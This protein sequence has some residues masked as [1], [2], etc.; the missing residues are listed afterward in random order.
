MA[1]ESVVAD[2]AVILTAKIDA[3]VA[4]FTEVGAS[5]EEMATKVTEATTQVTAASDKMT[6]SLAKVG[7]AADAAATTTNTQLS[8]ASGRFVSAGAAA[9]GMGEET[10]VAS[11]E[12]DAAT[13]RMA[14]ALEK[15]GIASETAATENKLAMEAMAAQT[16]ALSA[17][18]ELAAGKAAASNEGITAA[19]SKTG[20]ESKTRTRQMAK[21]FGMAA[22]AIGGVGAVAV[23]MAAKFQTSTTKLMTSAGESEQSI[24]Q[25]RQGML[26]MAGQV[27]VSAENLS[28]AMYQIESAGYHAQSGLGVLKAAEEGAKAEGADG[29][30]VAEALT[31]A[32][33]DYYPHAQSAADVTK[34]STDV[35]SKFIGATS[36]GKM[37]FDDL[38]GALSN[39][40]PAA[41]AANISLSDT[42]GVLASMT[43]HGIS[44]DQ[45]TQN[46]SDA[47]RHLQTPTQAMSKAMATLGIDSQD[48]AQ[49]LGQR[50]LSGTMQYLSD[51][52]KKAMPPGSDKVLLDLGNAASKSSPAVQDLAK[53]VLDGSITMGEFSKAAKGLDPISAKQAQAFAT[54]AGSYHQL[55]NQQ[56]SGATVMQTYS[57]M[58]SKVMGDATGLK[59]ALMTTK[60]NAGYTSDA[61]KQVANS[62]AEAGGN[63]K[64][65]HDVQDTFNQKLAESKAALGSMAIQIGN[66]LIP[67]LTPVV[68]LVGDIAMWLGKHPAVAQAAAIAIAALTVGFGA[69]AVAMWAASSTPVMWI[70]AAIVAVVVLLIAGIVLLV[71]HWNEVW[72]AV[73]QALHAVYTAVIKPVIDAIVTAAKAVGAAFTWLWQNVLKPVFD[74]ISFAVRAVALVIADVF[75][76]PTI[77]LVRI[78]AAIFTWLW[79]HAVK[80]AI[81]AI[82]RNLQGLYDNVF[83]PVGEAIGVAIHAIGDAAKWVWDNAIKPAIDAITTA[84]NWLYRNVFTPVGH[85]IQLEI[86]AIGTAASWV[87]DNVLKPVIDALAGAWHWVYDNAIKPVA[88]FIGSAVHGVGQAFSDAFNWV[89]S[90]VQDVWNFIKPIFDAIGNAIGGVSNA[91]GGIGNMISGTFSGIAHFLGFDDGGFVPGAP[92]QPMLAVVHGGEYVVSN[93]MQNGS[94]P[95][96]PKLGAQLTSSGGAP[97]LSAGLTGGGSGN[98]VVQIVVQGNAVTERQLID[99][100]QQGMLRAGQHRPVTYQNYRR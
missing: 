54:L 50:G 83:K 60:D 48:I 43:V 68:K 100:V 22:V 65:W 94:Q 26:D 90:I 29:T 61:I 28:N 47:I 55:G 86:K 63:V 81:D 37:T 44:A 19:I 58:M 93:A 56:I 92:G 18:M 3:A 17:K 87:W 67:I 46:M 6:E 52:V 39:V 96:D 25:V 73:G 99:V 77:I 80:P 38:S 84:W 5:G 1:T 97:S 98:T 76:A 91:L 49:K 57:G 64:G 88:D 9:Q 85:G 71:K 82:G 72:H 24:G 53:K 75:I 8:E 78:L 42:L 74:V 69:L 59:V 23:D 13:S 12:V 15:V 20:D 79:D 27:G 34:A 70:I 7:A 66:V 30:K 32:L 51:A 89:K 4:S 33:H 21:D 16:A 31:S 40:L 36:A 95:I 41:S 45:A 35:M 11:G 2:L 14:F 62:T 10:T